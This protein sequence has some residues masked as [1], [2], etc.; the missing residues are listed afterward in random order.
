M[1]SLMN[2][3]RS[4]KYRIRPIWHSF[5]C[6]VVSKQSDSSVCLDPA[7]F[8]F[9]FKSSKQNPN[10]KLLTFQLWKKGMKLNWI[11]FVDS[12]TQRREGGNIVN[13]RSKVNRGDSSCASGNCLLQWVKGCVQVNLKSQNQSWDAI[14]G[15]EKHKVWGRES[16]KV[17]NEA[18]QAQNL[19]TV[20]FFNGYLCSV[21]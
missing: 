4:N 7:V 17:E 13:L 10:R 20:I 6:L 18:Q 11:K 12:L 1:V 14:R 15:L 19:D 8:C 21:V 3:Y 5:P 16:R 2:L 9:A